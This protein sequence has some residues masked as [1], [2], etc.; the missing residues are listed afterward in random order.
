VECCGIVLAFPATALASIA[1][2]LF[3]T[4]VLARFRRLRRPLVAASLI[5]VSIAIIEVA[6][7]AVFGVLRVRA[8]LGW[9]F[10]LLHY[11]VFFC[12]PPAVCNLVHFL[13]SPPRRPWVV[14]AFLTFLVAIALVFYNIE[15]CE[16]LYGHDRMGGPYGT[17]W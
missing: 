3:A 5:L 16:I 12:T 1:Y 6:L 7:V 4:R 17:P 10:E 8:R 2:T 11:L 14:P 13:Q 15:V 9:P